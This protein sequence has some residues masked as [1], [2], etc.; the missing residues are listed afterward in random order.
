M[1]CLYRPFDFRH[2]YFSQVAMDYPRRE[3]LDHVAGRENLCLGFGRQGLAVNDPQWSLVA[4]AAIPIDANVFRRGGINVCPLYLYAEGEL[5]PQS[6]RRPNLGPAFLKSLAGKLRLPQTQPHGLPR[7]VAPED[8]FHYAYAVFHSPTY[9][10]R[11]GEFL[12]IDFPRLPLTSDPELFRSLAA[13]GAELAGLHLMDSPKL[14]DF[15]TEFAVRGDNEVEKAQYTDNDKRV[16]IN[17]KQYLSGVPK[18]VW[19]FHVGGYQVCEKWLKEHKGRKL[20]Y[21]DL[22]H[23]QKIVVALNETIRLTQ[24]IDAV[25][26]QH[27]GWPIK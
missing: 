2:C 19:Q 18:A 26:D 4:I 23:Y 8:I 3:L 10:R 24:K 21:D 7:G 22:Q 17:S 5:G 11:Y 14:N 6:G 20:A 27:G 9:R 15:L 1:E 12:K 13:E 25:I 16:W